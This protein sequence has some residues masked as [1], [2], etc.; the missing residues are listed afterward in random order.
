MVRLLSVALLKRT[1]LAMVLLLSGVAPGAAPLAATPAIAQTE[2]GVTI[3]G[4]AQCPSDDGVQ[5]LPFATVQLLSGSAEVARTTADGNANFTFT[6]AAQGALYQLRYTSNS[7]SQPQLSCGTTADTTDG[8]IL[9]PPPPCSDQSWDRAAALDPRGVTV[10]DTICKAN[11]SIWRKVAVQPGQQIS[12]LVNNAGPHTRVALFKD[13]RQDLQTLLSSPNQVD[14]QQL[15]ASMNG[16]ASSP[17]NSSPWNS[18]PWNSSPWNSSPWNSSPWNSSPWNSSP[19]NSS[20][21]DTTQLCQALGLSVSSD[22]CAGGYLTVQ[23]QDLLAWS[24]NG[25]IT[26]NTFDLSGDFYIRI[27]NDDASFDT[28]RTMTLLATV[29]GTCGVPPQSGVAPV[30]KKT[31]SSSLLSPTSTSLPGG[32]KTLIITDTARLVGPNGKPLTDA[33]N[34]TLLSSFRTTVNNFAN[35]SAVQGLVVDLATD[36]GLQAD[37]AQWDTPPFPSCPAAANVVASALHDLIDAY[38]VQSGPAFQYVTILGGH[39][40][41][42]YHLTTDTAELERENGYNPGLI[43]T[44]KSAASLANAYVMTDGYYVS[45]KPATRLESDVSLPDA[46]MAVGRIVEFP[47]DI[48]NVLQDFIDNNGVA[49]PTSALVTG[50]TFFTDLA[51]FEVNQLSSAGVNT[52][53]LI[54]D[55]WTASD[56]RG[57]L[58]GAAT[59]GIVAVNWHAESNQAVAAD[60]ATAHPT[61]ISTSEIAGLPTTD[62]RF[63]NTLVV[64]IGCHM[65]YPLIDGDV[66]PNPTAPPQFVTDQRA[67]TETFQNRG[68]MV[69]GNS[70]FGYGDTDFIGYSEELL[71]LVTQELTDG[72]PSTVPVGM[73]LTNAK[74]KYIQNSGATTGVDK[75]SLEELTFYGPPMWSI[76]LPTRVAKPGPN[77]QPVNPQVADESHSLSADTVAP[78]YTLT[79]HTLETGD[80]SSTYYEADHQSTDQ[81]AGKQ[82]VPYRATLPFKGF[83]ISSQSAGTARGVA[84]IGADYVDH[85]NSTVTVDLPATEVSGA[86][87]PWPTQGFWPFQTFSL[88]ELAGQELVTTPIQWQSSDGITGTTRQYDDS[89]TKLRV[90]YSNLTNGAAFAGPATINDVKLSPNG[91]LLHVDITVSGSSAADI[92]DVLVNYTV[93]PTPGGTG[94]W[95]TCSLVSS[96]ADGPTTTASCA[97]AFFLNSSSAPGSLVRHYFGDID[98]SAFP[99][100]TAAD[101]QLAIQ[102]VTGT[103]LVS[104]RNNDGRYF[105]L[106]T[107]TATIGNPKARTSVTISTLPSPITYG[108][109]ATFSATLNSNRANCSA[110]GQPLTFNIGSQV[111]TVNT[112]AGGTASA[113]FNVQ[114]VPANY[115]LIVTFA[116][117]ASCL[118]SSALQ[119][120]A[121]V[122]KE[123]T[124]LRFGATPYLAIL[125]DANGTPMRER[126][127]YFTFS[128]TSSSGAAVNAT[129]A[130]ETNAN[131]LAEL[132][133][134]SVPAGTYNVRVTF[135]GTI[136]TAGGGTINLTDPYY[137]ASSATTTVTADRTPPTCLLTSISYDPSGVAVSGTITVQDRG[138]GLASVTPAELGNATFSVPSYS[139]GITSPLAVTITRPNLSQAM[140]VAL[141]VADVDGN[142]THCVGDLVQV[143]QASSSPTQESATLSPIETQATVFNGTPGLENVQFQTDERTLGVTGLNAGE[144]RQLDVTAFVQGDKDEDD[145]APVVVVT[146]QGDRTGST[147][148][149]FSG[150]TTSHL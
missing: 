46:N 119:T 96:R 90:Y 31:A 76:G 104:S 56:L 146:A 142:M 19:W 34:A 27:Y 33:S 116:E 45:F 1:L 89:A 8:V 105:S 99:G 131:G 57:K 23:I 40:V 108:L 60:Y 49:H 52:D 2:P 73:A 20:P 32:K 59:P 123:A 10:S 110:S 47:V 113:T 114:E 84:L 117:N 87:P 38:R 67:F 9:P 79:Q 106:V 5:A 70:G 74:R 145:K 30:L 136:P 120:P 149:V 11:Q 125:T 22:T 42:P 7:D 122:N 85:P 81:A 98:P 112:N 83:D 3:S 101:L 4:T 97:N 139:A 43:D 93:P 140:H 88:N 16:T 29:I 86:R 41:V 26:R 50:Y 138:S 44:S 126:F 143:G 95:K 133:G 124:N 55:T 132:R 127:V 77:T 78:N 64:S 51:K 65:A 12:I 103:G 21:F 71:A 94:H 69:L 111:Q 63:K 109:N 141:D 53:S 37:Y 137:L 15:D 75:K 14:L 17:W 121:T 144:I 72:A 82:E 80:V 147:V 115:A 118:G 24:A 134:M 128:G 13:L 48:Q 25:Q 39:T 92:F 18:S 35:H 129:R 28:G 107:Q 62:T 150:Q 36:G 148:V 66:I 100:A 130:V 61:T 91:A 54:S 135:P 6:G 102:A 68:A 58:F